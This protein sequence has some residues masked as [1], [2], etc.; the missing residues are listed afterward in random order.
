MQAIRIHRFGEPDVLQLDELPTPAPGP[1]QALVRV[2][3]SGVN[4]LDTHHRSGTRTG[5]HFNSRLPFVPGFEGAGVV[6]ALGP[7]VGDVA[8]GDRV[9][10]ESVMAGASWFHV[11]GIT[12][13]LSGTAAAATGIAIAAAKRAGARVSVDLNYRSKL[14]T[15]AKAQATMRPFVREVDV[16]IRPR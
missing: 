14:W 4:F 5:P 3:A 16:V 7:D 6:E 12:P 11:T 8:V 2:A 10:W 1:G 9:A 15:E 13:A